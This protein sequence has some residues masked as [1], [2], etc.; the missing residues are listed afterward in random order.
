MKEK[1]KVVSDNSPAEQGTKSGRKRTLRRILLMIGPL[2][3]IV[4]GGGWYTVSGRYIATDN[5]YTKADIVS[6]AP[7]ISGPIIGVAVK[8]NQS[9][10]KGDVLFTIDPKPYQIALD[11]AQANLSSART[12]VAGLQ[13]QYAQSAAELKA[14][15]ADKTWAQKNYERIHSLQAKNSAAVSP[16]EI[17][18]VVHD[19]ETSSQHIAALEEQQARILAALEGDA[20]MPAENY[21]KIRAA[22]AAVDTAKL[23][24]DRTVVHAPQDGTIGPA[25]HGGDYAHAQ[26]PSMNVVSETGTWIEANYKET[27]LTRMRPGQSVSIE[28]DTYPGYKWA[29]KVESI[30]PASE[31]E[32][33]ILPAQNATGNWVKVVQRIPVRV[34]IEHRPGEP[35]IR[36]GMSA[37]VSVD[38][39]SYPHMPGAQAAT[40]YESAH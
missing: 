9:V 26:V 33:S 24:L 40:A 6:V 18:K 29:G 31:A 10:K 7:E 2:A 19:L 22:Q 3:V 23:N 21:A 17:D 4:I 13:A 16:T 38:T 35:P 12:E 37:D 11:L 32:F 5:A 15:A 28:I 8:D 1:I 36:G 25:P 14:A 39:G 27:D 34:S 20:N 30:S